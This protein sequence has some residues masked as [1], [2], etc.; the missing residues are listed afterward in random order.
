M[1]DSKY[2]TQLPDTSTR[3]TAV[4]FV[5]TRIVDALV[6]AHCGLGKAVFFYYSN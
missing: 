6:D 3:E 5:L 1:I 2:I 4:K